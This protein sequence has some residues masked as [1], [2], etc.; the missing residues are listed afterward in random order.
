[1]RSP[2]QSRAAV[3]RAVSGFDDERAARLNSA[4]RFAD[5]TLAAPQRRGA[6]R[7]ALRCFYRVHAPEKLADVT[8]RFVEHFLSQPG[9]LNR[10][11]KVGSWVMLVARVC[12]LCV[13]PPHLFLLLISSFLTPV[14]SKK[15]PSSPRLFS[16]STNTVRTWK[17]TPRYGSSFRRGHGA[18]R[19]AAATSRRYALRHSCADARR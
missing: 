7:A 15:H 17:A 3:S 1:M 10:T 9:F 4:R 11:L 8:D 13:R 19:R 16:L 6:L 18:S 5:G 12:Y 14:P 2:V